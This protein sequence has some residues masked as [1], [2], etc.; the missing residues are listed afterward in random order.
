MAHFTKHAIPP[1]LA[2]AVMLA[3]FVAAGVGEDQEYK[4]DASGQW[5][6]VLEDDGATIMRYVGTAGYVEDLVLVIPSELDGYPVMSIGELAFYEYYGLTNVT[7]PEGVTNIGDWAFYHCTELTSVTIPDSVISIGD[8]AFYTCALASVTIPASVTDI[9]KNPFA[10]CLTH[11]DVAVDNSVYEQ[12]DGVLFDKRQKMLVAHPGA[13]EEYHYTIPKG[14]LC[15]GDEAF[16]DGYELASVIIPDSVTSIG[17]MA[18]H[19]CLSLTSLTIPSSVA[20]IGGNAFQACD[21]LVLAVEECSYAEQY[22]KENSSRYTYIA[23]T[24]GK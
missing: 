23:E 10:G 17:E 13:R 21:N 6:Y 20:F 11:I 24:A 16:A 1:I 2:V 5:K 22:A 18:F 14:V 15:I 12:I 7:I 4:T 19:A 9:G 8:S 3:L